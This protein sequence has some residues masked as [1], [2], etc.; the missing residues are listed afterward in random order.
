MGKMKEYSNAYNQ[1]AIELALSSVTIF[2]C[3]TCG[4]PVLEG[5]ACYHCDEGSPVAPNQ[6]QTLIENLI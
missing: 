3:K 2:S 5:Y 4:H 1:E 6:E